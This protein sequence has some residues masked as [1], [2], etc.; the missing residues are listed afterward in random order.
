MT[1]L[2]ITDPGQLAELLNLVH[3]HWFNAEALVLDRGRRIVRMRLDPVR[4]Q[5]EMGSPNSVELEFRNV[6]DLAIEDTEHVRDYD[7]TQINYDATVGQIA[8]SGGIPIKILLRVT[9]L[10]I[11]V[12]SRVAATHS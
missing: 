6:D 4:S 3:D 5:L 2:V 1:R 11:D 7:L 12:L 9:A 10:E 8:I